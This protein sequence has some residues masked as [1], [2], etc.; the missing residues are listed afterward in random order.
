MSPLQ[1][2]DTR[3]NFSVTLAAIVS[4]FSFDLRRRKSQKG[5]VGKRAACV[6]S[7]TIIMVGGGRNET[8][9]VWA[10]GIGSAA[11]ISTREIDRY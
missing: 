4:L 3:L 1:L 11:K 10:A 2:T 5:C 8:V 9:A 6:L 7:D